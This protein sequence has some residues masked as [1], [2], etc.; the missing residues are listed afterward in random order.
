[1]TDITPE[2]LSA[3]LY[4][5]GLSR[6]TTADSSLAYAADVI[7]EL[8]LQ[9]AKRNEVLNTKP[10]PSDTEYINQAELAAAFKRLKFTD[11]YAWPSS[12][13]IFAQVKA[14]R[15]PEWQEGD[16]VQAQ[17][18]VV[19]RRHNGTWL[20]FGFAGQVRHDIPLRP[21]KHLGKDKG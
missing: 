11:Y 17:N 9:A 18:G 19:Y 3:A 21:L 8:E 6:K 1:M 10:T 14:H 12:E 5:V 2:R 15:E 16:V 20:R 4:A 7:R 13:Y